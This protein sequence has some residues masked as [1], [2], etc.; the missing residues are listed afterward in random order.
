MAVRCIAEVCSASKR[1]RKIRPHF[2]PFA[3]VP[4]DRRLPAT[5]FIGLDFGVVNI[6]RTSDGKQHSGEGIEACRTRYSRLRR[7]LHQEAR[8]NRSAA[9]Q[10]RP[11]RAASF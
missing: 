8:L 5:D 1:D 7:S 9:E 6:A 11:L 3:A 4:Y 10:T 2:R